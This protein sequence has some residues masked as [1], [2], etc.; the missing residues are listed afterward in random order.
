MNLLIC[1]SDNNDHSGAFLCLVDLCRLLRDK[2]EDNVIVILPFKGTGVK[3]LEKNNIQYKY[4]H[5]WPWLIKKN[6]GIGAFMK[7]KIQHMLNLVAI[8]RL[9]YII[10][11]YDI[12][13]V[14]S[15]TVWGYV[16]IVAAKYMNVN[17]VWHFRE[18]PMLSQ[19]MDWGENIEK[20]KKY[21]SFPYF[22][23]AVSQYVKGY[24]EKITNNIV[25]IYD[26][27]HINEL[28]NIN[29]TWNVK[30]KIRIGIIGRICKGKGQ[31]FIIDTIMHLSKSVQNKFEL[32]II[33]DGELNYLLSLQ[34][35]VVNN[36]L[37]SIVSFDGVIDNIKDIYSNIDVVCIC[38]PHEAF[39]RTVIEA[40]GG[41]CLVVGVNSGSVK[42]II[43]NNVDGFLYED[44]NISS[45]MNVIEFIINEKNNNKIIEV[46]KNGRLKAKEY[47]VEK[48]VDKI[49]S[50][51]TKA[52]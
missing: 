48:N 29:K 41:G 30:E 24:Y 2:Y 49:H 1:A 17:S 5:S 8:I 26:G 35:K 21:L 31:E 12:D 40:M 19:G 34:K 51:Y 14:H 18:I 42:E 27:V 13:I 43:T 37:S 44:N 50:L 7:Y 22:K 52:F 39:G 9:C 45:L 23:I 28:I 46:I 33:G 6:G 16:G 47:S 4:V 36:Q 32:H 10:K 20:I 11:K 38:S 3:L 25:M 15:N